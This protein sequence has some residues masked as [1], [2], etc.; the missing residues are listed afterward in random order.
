MRGVREARRRG[1]GCIAK[2]A[3]AASRTRNA[4]PR[5]A[6]ACF[7]SRFEREM[8]SRMLAMQSSVET[9]LKLS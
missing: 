2:E 7:V 1:E 6:S 9:I 8:K 3:A 4:C 5:F